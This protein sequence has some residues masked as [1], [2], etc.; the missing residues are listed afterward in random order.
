MN[1]NEI[2]KELREIY[3]H[4]SY[5]AIKA[6]ADIVSKASEMD[7]LYTKIL[8]ENSGLV[9]SHTEIVEDFKRASDERDHVQEDGGIRNTSGIGWMMWC[10]E[11]EKERDE[12]RSLLQKHP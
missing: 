11:A 5:P 7:R 9:A 8:K 6:A 1:N 2:V 10:I 3:D 12:A 4:M